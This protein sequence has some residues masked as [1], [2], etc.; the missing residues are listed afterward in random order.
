MIV[1]SSVKEH[2]EPLDIEA[3]QVG[4]EVHLR[5]KGSLHAF[6]IVK[7]DDKGVAVV[8]IS[9]ISTKVIKWEDLALLYWT[10]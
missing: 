9:N 8:G 4:N 1:L 3:V 2:H 6:V 10:R 7:R 5:K